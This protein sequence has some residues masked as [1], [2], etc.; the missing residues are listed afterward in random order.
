M[1]GSVEK[2]GSKPTLEKKTRL[3]SAKLS[4]SSLSVKRIRVRKC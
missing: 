3:L 4:L 1:K 2:L